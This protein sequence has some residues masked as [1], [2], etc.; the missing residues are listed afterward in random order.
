MMYCTPARTRLQLL[1]PK[2]YR[3]LED[4][5]YGPIKVQ[6]AYVLNVNYLRNIISQQAAQHVR[7]GRIYLVDDNGV[8]NLIETK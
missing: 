4:R 3:I 7:W 2:S 6:W 1:T 8:I 5:I